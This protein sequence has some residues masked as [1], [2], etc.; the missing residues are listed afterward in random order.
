M[1]VLDYMRLYMYREVGFLF[2][3]FLYFDENLS[4]CNIEWN[5][6]I[7][8]QTLNYMYINYSPKMK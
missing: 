1:R 8:K 4:K 5:S 2:F 7:T 6:K 3:S